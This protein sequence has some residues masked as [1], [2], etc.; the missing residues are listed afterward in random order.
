MN[1]KDGIEVNGL[2][3]HADFNLHIASR[4]IG[5]PPKKTIL[6]EIPFM[7][8]AYD[9]TTLAGS[10]TFGNRELSYAFDIIG[11]TVEQMDLKRTDVINWFCNMHEVDIFD[12]TIPDYHFH[13]SFASESQNEDAEKTE[14]TVTFNCYPFKIANEP[15]KTIINENGTYTIFNIGQPV[16]LKAVGSGTIKLNGK[17][18]AFDS[19]TETETG[20]Y[21]ARGKNEISITL[22]ETTMLVLSFIKEVL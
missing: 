15:E 8:G 14:L 22:S 13:G 1:Y 4:T 2:H 21:L 9:F 16:E 3:S 5:N 7:N 17:Q 10:A 12:D 18:V 11:E 20:L 19:E 6:K